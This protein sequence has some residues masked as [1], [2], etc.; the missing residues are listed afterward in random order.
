MVGRRPPRSL[1]AARRLATE[2]VMRS[3]LIPS[4]IRAGAAMTV[5]TIDP[6]RGDGVHVSPTKVA[7]PQAVSLAPALFG[8]GDH[9]LRRPPQPVQCRDDQRVSVLQRR[10]A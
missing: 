7:D 4:S 8:E 9:V 3:R 1:P 6:I 10:G 2:S 5:K